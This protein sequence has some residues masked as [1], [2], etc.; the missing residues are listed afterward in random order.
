MQALSG[1]DFSVCD[2]EFEIF[3]ISNSPR[4][5]LARVKLTQAEICAT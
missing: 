2:F 4:N 3:E 1:T 5:K